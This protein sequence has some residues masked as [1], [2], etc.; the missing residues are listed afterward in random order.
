[1]TRVVTA[2]EAVGRISLA[3]LP[4][5]AAN[6]SFIDVC[7]QEPFWLPEMQDQQLLTL[8]WRSFFRWWQGACCY[9]FCLYTMPILQ[10]CVFTTKSHFYYLTYWTK[11]SSTLCWHSFP[12]WGREHFA[13]S[14]SYS[15]CQHFHYVYS[16]PNCIF[17]TR[18]TA[19]KIVDAP[20]TLILPWAY[21]QYTIISFGGIYH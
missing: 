14:F 17:I 11:K 21:L 19:P 1:M 20:L 13:F 2:W 15:G 5:I 3:Y 8:C 10:L 12:R 7:D 6:S 16:L 4:I 18:L 9:L